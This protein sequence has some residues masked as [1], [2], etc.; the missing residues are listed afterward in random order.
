MLEITEDDVHAILALPK[1]PL[2]VQ[3]PSACEPRN[4]Y[5]KTLTQ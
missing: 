4:K 3:I 5:A 1:G 2:E